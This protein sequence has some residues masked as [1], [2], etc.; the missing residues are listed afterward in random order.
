MLWCKSTFYKPA[1][2]LPVYGKKI[3]PNSLARRSLCNLVVV[4]SF[5]AKKKEKD[6]PFS[7]RQQKKNYLWVVLRRGGSRQR[8]LQAVVLRL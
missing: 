1:H 4:S 8:C 7:N 2:I 5:D 6:I 3:L